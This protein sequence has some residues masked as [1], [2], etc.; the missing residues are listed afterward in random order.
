M[1]KQIL[2]LIDYRKQFWLTTRH[3]QASFDIDA[4]QKNF[5]GL[6]YHVEVRQFADINFLNDNYSGWHVFY[7]STE[8]P[9][10]LYNDFIEDILLGLKEQ[11]AILIPEFKYFR[12]HHNKVFMEILR[13]IS[14]IP[15]LQ[16]IL[17]RCFGTFEEYCRFLN[18]PDVFFPQVV[19]LGEG[20]QSKNVRLIH[21]AAEASKVKKMMWFND[22]KFWLKDKIKALWKS[23]YPNF[24]PQSSARRKIIVQNFI[25]G[26]TGDYKVLVFGNKYYVLNRKIRPGD[27]RASGSGLF[28]FPEAPPE[29]L[30]NFAELVF[31]SFKVPFISLDLAC[32]N[33]QCHLI[34][35]Q[36][37]SFGTYTI[38]KAQWHFEKH[39]DKW[40]RIPGQDCLEK[41]FAEA[42]DKFLSHRY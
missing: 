5:T 38:E 36:F 24:R 37:I 18:S 4:M 25:P 14:G 15:A 19:K 20:A 26:L 21:S 28:T 32:Q 42:V 12:A 34:E 22:W 39:N 41:E 30:L 2:I 40:S 1:K 8:D 13:S 27:F 9:Y 16:S 17:S 35:F 11:G 31:T 6:G 10:L 33:E 3:K 7:Q 23:R 29:Q